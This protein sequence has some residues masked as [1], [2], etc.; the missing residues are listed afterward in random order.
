MSAS[1]SSLRIGYLGL[2]I[3][4]LPMT[5][6]LLKAGHAVKVWNR[7]AAKAAPALAAGATQ[8]ATPAEVAAA[9]DIVFVNV[10]DTPDVEAVLFGEGGVASGAKPGLIVVDN[11]TISPVATQAF[12]LRLKKQGVTFLDAPVSGGDIGA[13]NGTLS[14]MVGGDEAAFETI[15]PV[16]AAMGKNI[17][18]LGDVGAGQACKACNQICV[19]GNLL[20]ACEA[21]KLA[22]TFGLDIEKMASVV[23]GGAGGSW[24]L[25]NLT[26]KI[27]KGDFAPAFMI[28]LALKDLAIVLE[29]AQKSGYTL[30]ATELAEARLKTA[31]ALGGGRQGTQAMIKA[32]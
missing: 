23:S 27:A 15:K 14:I 11:S 25:Q 4:G 5:L 8:G 31:K 18:R 26:P 12:A 2:G 7:T 32:V 29:A 28:D 1:T 16:L 9:S 3:M 24:Q 20:A 19:L 30:P 13:K 21:I 6:N 22:R 17:Q 10:T